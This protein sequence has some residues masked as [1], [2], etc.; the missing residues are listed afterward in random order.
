MADARAARPSLIPIPTEAFRLRLPDEFHPHTIEIRVP[1]AYG[2]ANWRIR[3][4]EPK[5]GAGRG[6]SPTWL[7]WKLQ[8]FQVARLIANAPLLL[9]ALREAKRHIHVDDREAWE[10]IDALLAKIEGQS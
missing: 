1:Y 5:S 6:C 3:A 9:E 8:D 10:K 2:S 4:Q 7:G